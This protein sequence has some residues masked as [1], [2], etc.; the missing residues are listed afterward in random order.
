[1]SHDALAALLGPRVRFAVR[2]PG[3][4]PVSVLRPEEAAAVSR[5]VEGRRLEM[6]AGRDAARE[7]LGALGVRPGPIPKGERGAP[8]WPAG[9][10][11]SITHT[12]SFCLAAVAKAEAVEGLGVDAEPDEPL[13][14]EL[15]PAI[16]TPAERAA[17]AASEPRAAGARA[18]RL[19]CA[20]EAAYKAQY[21]LTGVLLEFDDLA[22]RFSE[23]SSS[24]RRC[25]FEARYRR[26]TGPF[27][28]G[29]TLRGRILADGGQLV[30][31]VLGPFS[32]NGMP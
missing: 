14:P 23:P 15:W 16:T 31:A 6:A 4:V 17:L 8:V 26:D 22:I 24:A 11:G 20:K 29:R 25:S 3:D 21:P 7:A 10:V 13:E 2:R 28:A 19:F 1:M 9:V 18:R 32:A 30:A 5:A 27:P 12:R